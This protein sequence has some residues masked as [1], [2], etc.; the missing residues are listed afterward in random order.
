MAKSPVGVLLLH[1]LS[2]HINCIDPVVPRLQKLGIPYRMPVLRGHGTQPSDLIGV[3]WQDWV[4]DGQKAL[5]DLLQ[6]CEKAIIVGLSMGGV[7]ALNLTANNQSRV[8]GLVCIAPALKLKSKLSALAPLIALVQKT[9]VF[10]P[11]PLGYFDQEAAKTSL[12]YPEVPTSVVV[13]LIKFGKLTARPE[14]LSRIK[15]P[16]LILQTSQDRTVDPS[17]AQHLHDNLGSAD[18][19]LIWFHRSGHEMLRDAQRE[20]ILDEIEKFVAEIATKAQK[21][22]SA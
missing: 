2:S 11:D 1:G 14:F 13:E 22:V 18:R 5:D 17:M 8:E 21:G 10:K 4:E 16:T 15:V 6:E 9:L 20:E 12:N 3:K 19:R 7:V